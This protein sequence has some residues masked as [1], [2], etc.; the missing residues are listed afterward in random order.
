M[1]GLVDGIR[2]MGAAAR[3]AFEIEAGPLLQTLNIINS[4][5]KSPIITDY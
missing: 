3:K 5:L 1:E 2:V 4:K